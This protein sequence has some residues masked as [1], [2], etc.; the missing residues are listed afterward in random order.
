MGL[1]SRDKL[2]QFSPE[3]THTAGM[4]AWCESGM[5]LTGSCFEY[6]VSWLWYS[7][8]DL[9]G[10]T[11]LVEIDCYVSFFKGFVYLVLSTVLSLLGS[12]LHELSSARTFHCHR[13]R[14]SNMAF[15]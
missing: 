14:H 1:G 11:W 7:F 13:L 3:R 6:S 10:G 8:E 2:S 12:C 5:F 15:L 9:G 4:L